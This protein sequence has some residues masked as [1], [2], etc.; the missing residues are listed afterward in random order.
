MKSEI[1]QSEKNLICPKNPKKKNPK[2][3]KKKIKKIKKKSKK[4]SKKSKKNQK[5]KSKKKMAAGSDLWAIG[6]HC[7]LK[8][9]SKLDFLPIQCTGCEEY[10]C[11]D[12]SKADQHGCGV[13]SNLRTH[14]CPN[15]LRFSVAGMRDSQAVILLQEHSA[16]GSCLGKKTSLNK[17]T[18]TLPTGRPCRKSELV[19]ALC[20]LCNELFCFTHVAPESHQCKILKQQK[21]QLAAEMDAKGKLVTKKGRETLPLDGLIVTQDSI[22]CDGAVQEK[23]FAL[24]FY[25]ATGGHFNSAWAKSSKEGRESMAATFDSQ[26]RVAVQFP[27]HIWEVAGTKYVF[28]GHTFALGIWLGG[29]DF[30][31]PEEYVLRKATIDLERVNLQHG[32]LCPFSPQ[33]E[34]RTLGYL[35]VKEEVKNLLTTAPTDMALSIATAHVIENAPRY[36]IPRPADLKSIADLAARISA[37]YGHP[38]QRFPPLDPSLSSSPSPLSPSLLTSS[39]LSPSPPTLS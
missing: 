24:A 16:T 8:S 32:F 14:V 1:S 13:L 30:L 38:L 31:Y 35:T 19:P 23:L 2:K 37:Q 11:G 10:F 39:S 7:A 29:R 22:S 3:I 9:C 4:K 5:K 34:V 21:E 15:C 28:R 17:C 25:V 26:V 27:I 36:K 20:S 6:K 33:D 12:H 18:F